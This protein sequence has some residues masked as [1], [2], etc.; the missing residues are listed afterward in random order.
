METTII[1]HICVLLY[2]LSQ[3]GPNN[4]GWALDVCKCTAANWLKI[5]IYDPNIAQSKWEK[6]TLI[7][8]DGIILFFRVQ[9]FETLNEL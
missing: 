2:S 5:V 4:L 6:L 3:P 8:F 7:G 9:V 1:Q